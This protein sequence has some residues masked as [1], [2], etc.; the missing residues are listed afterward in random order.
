MAK[1]QKLIRQRKEERVFKTKGTACAKGKPSKGLR[2]IG[3]LSAPKS[4]R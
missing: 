4:K 1:K 3:R 2:N